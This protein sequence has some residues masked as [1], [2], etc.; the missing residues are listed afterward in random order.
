MCSVLRVHN[1][2][3]PSDKQFTDY[4]DE[5]SIYITIANACYCHIKCLSFFTMLIFLGGVS[6]QWKILLSLYP[7][8]RYFWIDLGRLSHHHMLALSPFHTFLVLPLIDQS[9]SLAFGAQ[10]FFSYY[11]IQWIWICPL[12]SSQDFLFFPFSPHLLLPSFPSSYPFLFPFSS[13]PPKPNVSDQQQVCQVMA[14]DCLC[15]TWKQIK[16]K[17]D[18][19]SVGRGSDRY[20]S[21]RGNIFAE[22]EK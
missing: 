16:P 9:W 10:T 8:D 2:C 21:G 1:L 17:R 7:S 11:S 5:N 20:T 14:Y 18:L 3:P 12:I 6:K 22:F 15:E 4:F 19:F 13:P